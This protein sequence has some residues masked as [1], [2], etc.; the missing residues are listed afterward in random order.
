MNTLLIGA[1]TSLGLGALTIIHPCPLSTNI[2]AVSFLVGWKQNFKTKLL[3]VSLF[4]LGE[5]A[6]F[7][8]LGALISFGMLSIAPAAN[9]LQ[10]YVL[11]LFG[12]ILILA[13]MMLLGILFPKQSTIRIA[14]HLL[15][16]IAKLGIWAGLFFGI[17]VALS[18]CPMSAAIYFGVLIPLAISSHTA[19]LFPVFFGI[20]ASLPLVLIVIVVSQSTALFDRSFLFKKSAGKK[21]REIAG[22]ATIFI[23][24]YMSLRYIF[25]IF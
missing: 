1:L 13:G 4:V 6:T 19:V 17:L 9:F 15:P 24:I 23:G 20:G 7:A 14:E 2:A 11:Q 5:I 21:L 3:M 18:F 10:V 8:V 25:D 12:P 22:A 16:R